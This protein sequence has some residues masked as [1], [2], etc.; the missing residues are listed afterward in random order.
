MEKRIFIA[1]LVSIALL[2]GWAVLAPRLF[3]EYAKPNKPAPAQTTAENKP[4][5]PAPVSAT[6]S[7]SSPA[8]STSTPVSKPV[9]LPST[10]VEATRVEYTTI[11]RPAFIAR[12]SNRGAQLVSFQLTGYKTKD[13]KSNVELVKSRDMSRTDFPFSIE[14]RNGALAARLNTALYA[15]RQYEDKGDTVVEFHYA[16]PGVAEATKTFRFHSDYLFDFSVAVQPP[17]PYRIVIGPGIRTLEPDE[18]DSQFII[19]GN[20]VMQ[21]DNDLKIVRREKAPNI[22]GWDSVQFVGIEDNYFMTALRPEKSGGAL[23]RAVDFG[24]DKA[25]RREIYAG[26]NSAPDGALSGSAFFGPKETSLLDKYG[27]E[28]T[29]QYGTFGIIARFFLVVLTWINTFTHNWGWA[30]I[31]L[32]ILI[33]VVLYP[34][35]HKWM[36]SMRKIQKVQPKMEAIKARYKKHR[37]DPEQRQKMNAEVM[38]LYQQEGINPAGGCLPMVIQFPIF[39]AFYNLLSHAIE[40]RGA[41][42]GLWIHDLSVKDPTYILPIL[43][44]V[45]MFV[46]Q[47]ITPTTADPQQRRMFLIMPIVFGW[48][49]KEFPSGL[50]L[51]WLVQNILTIVQQLVTN[52]Y[53]KDHPGDANSA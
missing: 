7:T 2:W 37:T 6:T 26:V 43:M 18:T 48:I 39:I 51:Y 27:F 38:K 22:A 25:K 53:W 20:G 47:F 33:K 32:T 9:A 10:A 50:T 52:R 29:L 15:V 4:P 42:F 16:A 12:F 24:K 13:R 19:T 17:T 44:T 8:A 14:G 41:P 28:K 1:V 49:F 21:R 35:Q 34:L 3:P 46:Q 40:L 5:A 31:V 45:A 11:E 36:L 23:L 30:I